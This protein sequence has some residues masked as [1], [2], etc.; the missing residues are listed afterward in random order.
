MDEEI[1]YHEIAKI[2]CSSEHHFKR[3]FS[4]L[5]GISLSEYVQINRTISRNASKC[6]GK[7]I[8]RVVPGIGV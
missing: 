3:I 7:D 1:D 6:V 2:A 8:F 4:F 5:V